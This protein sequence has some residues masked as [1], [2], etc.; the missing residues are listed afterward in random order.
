MFDGR[1]C[2]REDLSLLIKETDRIKLFLNQQV[3]DIDRLVNRYL[4]FIE[5]YDADIAESMRMR[6]D[7]SNIDYEKII[8]VIDTYVELL[9]QNVIID[10]NEH[11]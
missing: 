10:I 7:L 6:I 11:K 1:H 8:K 2:T 9:E 3:E 4:S 5:R